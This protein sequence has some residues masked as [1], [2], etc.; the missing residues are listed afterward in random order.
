[1][2]SGGSFPERGVGLSLSLSLCLSHYS[3][4][5]R[6]VTTDPRSLISRGA[7]QT[8]LYYSSRGIFGGKLATLGSL[9]SRKLTLPNPDPDP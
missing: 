8:T 6:V 2:I 5:A 4:S 9:G 7:L 1:M 3:P